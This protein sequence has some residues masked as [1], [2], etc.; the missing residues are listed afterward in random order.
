MYHG[1]IPT[2]IRIASEEGL[3]SLWKGNLPAELMYVSYSAIQFSIYRLSTHFLQRAFDAHIPHAAESFISGAVA[4]GV[5]TCATYPLDLLRTRFAAQGTTR[6]YKNLWFGI[7]EIRRQEGCA[8]FFRGLSA[9]VGQIIPYMGIFFASYETLREPLSSLSLPFG[10]S[11]AISGVLAAV[12]GKTAV[13]PLDLVRKRLQVQGPTRGLYVH[14]DIPVYVGVL[15]S[16][17]RIVQSEGPR[18]LYRGL[19]VSLVK[20]APTS[21]VT[22]WVY[23]RMLRGLKGME[24]R[25]EAARSTP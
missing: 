15:S 3:T 22:M 8:G 6:V 17:R 14:R 13:F 23:E 16:M 24:E 12:A 11:D 20:A 21:A 25:R 9:G 4:G 7:H 2:L 19:T 18:G 5:A 10:S 1:T